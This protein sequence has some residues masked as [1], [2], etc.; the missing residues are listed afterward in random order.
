MA[1]SLRSKTKRAFRAKKREDGVYA[2]THAAR[3]QRLHEKIDAIVAAPKPI[4]DQI[5][6][7]IENTEG[8]EDLQRGEMADEAQPKASGSG[9]MDVDKTSKSTKIDTHGPRNSR[10]EQWRQ[11]KGMSARPERKGVNRQGGIPARRNAGRPKRRR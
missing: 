9:T 11:S 4:H 2:A 3:L 1:K 6:E 5:L 7:D 8:D 10:R